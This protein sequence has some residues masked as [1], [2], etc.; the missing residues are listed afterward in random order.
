MKRIF[1]TLAAIVMMCMMSACESKNVTQGRELYR[2]Y[3]Y[4]TA[5]VPDELKI[6][7]ESFVESENGLTVKW[8]VDVGGITR[9][10]QHFRRTMHFET[11]GGAL[12]RTDNGDLIDASQIK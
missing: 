4:K 12:L 9:G 1:Y 8:T 3:L 10:G 11:N 7:D 6:Y 5:I 2:A